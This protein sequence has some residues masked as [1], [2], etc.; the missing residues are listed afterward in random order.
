M[1]LGGRL[2]PQ[3][4]DRVVMHG[5]WAMRRRVL[6]VHLRGADRAGYVCLGRAPVPWGER[7]RP[8]AA[9]QP[10]GTGNPVLSAWSTSGGE[11]EFRPERCHHG[12]GWAASPHPPG[13]GSRHPQSRMA[14]QPRRAVTEGRLRSLLRSFRSRSPSV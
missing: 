14:A 4:R 8:A 5:G 10:G 9:P 7:A 1:L 11:T 13:G 12:G 3:R 6:V 2:L